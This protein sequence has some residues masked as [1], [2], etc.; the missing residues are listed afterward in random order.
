MSLLSYIW[1]CMLM[2]AVPTWALQTS[3]DNLLYIRAIEVG[4]HDAVQRH[5]WPEDQL[6]AVVKV[7]GNGILQ[8]VEQQGVLWAMWQ[9][10][11]DVNTVG[12]Q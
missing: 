11:A 6:M 8:V 3:G 12:K 5:I 2:A 1:T 9:N 4:L 10:L 7:Q